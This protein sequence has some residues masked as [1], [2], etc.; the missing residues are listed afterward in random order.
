[1]AHVGAIGQI[2]GAVGAHK[3]LIEKRRFVARSA[4]R[5]KNRTIGGIGLIESGRNDVN[6]ILP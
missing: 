3:R 5:V 4:R 2:V 1:M 6:G